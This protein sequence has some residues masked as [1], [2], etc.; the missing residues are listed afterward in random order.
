MTRNFFSRSIPDKIGTGG[1]LLSSTFLVVSF[2][3]SCSD[4]R[5]VF[6]QH[7]ELSDNIQWNR[8][9]IKSFT[10][11]ISDNSKP[12]RF[13]VAFRYA[14]G[15]YYANML[16]RLTETDPEGN[17]TITDLDIPTRNEKGEWIGDAG[18]D[19]MD[20]EYEIMNEKNFPVLGNY[21]YTIEHTMAEDTLHYAME[22]GLVLRQM[23]IENEQLPNQQ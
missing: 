5:T 9:D 10:I 17:I 11:P 16:M 7:Q 23:K 20:L 6:E 18:Y 22:V 13:L 2:L 3:F 21:T 8:S 19:I 4:Q 1:I 12:F 14:T 15:F